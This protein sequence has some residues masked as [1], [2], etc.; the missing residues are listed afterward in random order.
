MAFSSQTTA[1]GVSSSWIC[2]RYWSNLSCFQYQNCNCRLITTQRRTTNAVSP[3][4]DVDRLTFNANNVA[5]FV[6]MLECTTGKLTR[7]MSWIVTRLSVKLNKSWYS[8][9]TSICVIGFLLK[10]LSYCSNWRSIF[11][12]FVFS[13]TAYINKCPCRVPSSTLLSET[14]DGI[15]FMIFYGA[16]SLSATNHNMPTTQFGLAT[17]LADTL[18]MLHALFSLPKPWY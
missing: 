4:N 9:I 12:S 15:L 17:M 10:F 2:S 5:P 1:L 8:G 18:C 3:V 6:L 14:I 7:L 11:P 16:V 13:S